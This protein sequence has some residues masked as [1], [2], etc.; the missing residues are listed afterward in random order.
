MISP[1]AIAD[2]VVDERSLMLGLL[3]VNVKI[4]DMRPLMS[5]A[6]ISA[7]R[8]IVRASHP[9]YCLIYVR[10]SFAVEVC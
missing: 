2:E 9:A 10:A 4:S 1:S 6:N 7:L 3:E 5:L 8:A